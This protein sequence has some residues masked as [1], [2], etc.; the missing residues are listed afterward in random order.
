MALD[1]LVCLSYLGQ[2]RILAMDQTSRHIIF[3]VPEDSLLGYVF[4]YI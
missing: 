4:K 3:I 2:S 1:N